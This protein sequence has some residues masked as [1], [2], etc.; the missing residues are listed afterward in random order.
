VE[1]FF[2]V[3]IFTREDVMYAIVAAKICLIM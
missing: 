2:G 3:T 1:F